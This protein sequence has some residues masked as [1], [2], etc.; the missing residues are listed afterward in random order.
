[1]KKKVNITLP[2]PMEIDTL[3]DLID[4]S[5]WEQWG[6]GW[7]EII[8]IGGVNQALEIHMDDPDGNGDDDEPRQ[9]VK[10]FTAEQIAESISKMPPAEA[11]SAQV[12]Q[13]IVNE[14][15]DAHSADMICQ[16][17]IFGEMVYA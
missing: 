17:L 1:M 9:I 6:W 2:V 4:G 8:T 7:S 13:D 3:F 14:D 15:L 11:F 16:W 10:S 12:W 5:G